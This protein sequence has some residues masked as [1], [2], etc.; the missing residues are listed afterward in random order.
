MPIYEYSCRH[1]CHRFEKL[2]KNESGETVACPKCGSSVVAR[3]LSSFS[4]PGSLSSA[5][6][7]S[8]G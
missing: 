3:E 4:S 8:G 5:S 1:C 6:C 7:T 2:H